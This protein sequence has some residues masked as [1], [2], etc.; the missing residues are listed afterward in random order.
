MR[1]L[2]GVRRGRGA[3][4]GHHNDPE[5]CPS[6]TARPLRPPRRRAH[7][8]SRYDTV[9]ACVHVSCSCVCV[10]CV[11]VC[12]RVCVC[13]VI[14]YNKETI[15]NSGASLG[16]VCSYT[17]NTR[18]LSLRVSALVPFAVHLPTHRH[19]P[20]SSPSPSLSQGDMALK[21]LACSDCTLQVSPAAPVF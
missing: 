18:T 2:R 12:A 21:N 9:C 7:T 19:V 4:G 14:L 16:F 1:R 13:C 10:V 17:R 3:G 11:C 5:R 6:R 15:K 8:A 20:I